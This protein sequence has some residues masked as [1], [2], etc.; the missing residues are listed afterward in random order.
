MSLF[1]R[2]LAAGLAPSLL[3][4]LVILGQARDLLDLIWLVV[5][6]VWSLGYGVM[7]LWLVR[8]PLA[9]MLVVVLAAVGATG[10]T[11]AAYMALLV[12]ALGFRHPY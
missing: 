2:R 11:M 7:F 3:A 6:L 4:L 10:L 1:L 12:W 5:W 8:K 9:L